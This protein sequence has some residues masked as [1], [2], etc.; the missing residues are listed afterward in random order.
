M[1]VSRENMVSIM[2]SLV[3][4]MEHG[5]VQKG[6]CHGE[7][8]GSEGAMVNFEEKGLLELKGSVDRFGTSPSFIL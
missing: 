1:M 3:G 7:E 4:M 2:V 5:R 6:A 8:P